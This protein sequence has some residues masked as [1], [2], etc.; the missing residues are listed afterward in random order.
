MSPA[1]LSSLFRWTFCIFGISQ[2][3]I[4]NRSADLPLVTILSSLS[5]RYVDVVPA[6]HAYV[7]VDEANRL[8]SQRFE[9]KAVA[10]YR[11]HLY[12]CEQMDDASLDLLSQYY[13]RERRNNELVIL[14]SSYE[15]KN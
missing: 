7:A 11:K 8:Y 3:Q 4:F 5:Y 15:K 13:Y 12:T 10:I 1:R 9:T 14:V 6:L 2:A